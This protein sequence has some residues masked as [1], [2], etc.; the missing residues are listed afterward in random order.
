MREEL[1][2][3]IQKIIA[4]ELTAAKMVYP[5]N[6]SRHESI[7]ILAEE[8]EE[9]RDE[10]KRLE[11]IIHALWIDTKENT[12]TEEVKGRLTYAQRTAA[13][14]IAE[15]V[16]TAAMIVKFLEYENSKIAPV[17]PQPS[18][19]TNRVWTEEQK[20]DIALIKE[21]HKAKRLTKKM[22]SDT[23][24]KT[25]KETRSKAKSNKRTDIDDTLIVYMRDVQKRTI[26]QIA[27]EIKCCPQTVL[28]RYNR[29]KRDAEKGGKA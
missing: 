5:A 2:R 28:N 10:V 4:D 19:L 17:Q 21:A 25:R 6:N 20:K 22:N 8:Y 26:K 23:M 16:Q 1:G 18:A 11:Y 29:A 14:L 9:L 13:D 12:N 24:G 15:A 7:A 27:K 3:Q